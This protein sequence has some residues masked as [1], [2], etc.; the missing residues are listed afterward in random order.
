MNP[1][2]AQPPNVHP[3]G[4]QPTDA[5]SPA[6][7]GPSFR[8]RG[9]ESS[10]A[11]QQGAHP[12]ASLRL[13]RINSAD[14]LRRSRRIY[15]RFLESCPTAP[16]PMGVVLGDGPQGR[17]VFEA[18]IL[19]PEEHFVPMELLRPRPARNRGNRVPAS[20]PLP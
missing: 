2:T 19:L 11:L 7:S 5:N 20:R 15:F 3:P 6:S 14:L 1:I 8:I 13:D 12:S 17:V 9:G 16:D 4:V 18:P 10:S